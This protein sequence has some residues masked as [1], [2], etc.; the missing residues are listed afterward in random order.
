MAFRRGLNEVEFVEGQNVAIEQRWAEGQNDRLPA[1]LADL[2]RRKAA[3]I[4]ANG[5]AALAAK[6]ATWLWRA[7]QGERRACRP[8]P[9]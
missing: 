8:S 1:L 6:A 5:L 9:T 3:V 2:I 4:V 7:G